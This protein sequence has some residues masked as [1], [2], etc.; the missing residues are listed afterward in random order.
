MDIDI[1]HNDIPQSNSSLIHEISIKYTQNQSDCMQKRN[2]IIKNLGNLNSTYTIDPSSTL[3]SPTL[4]EDAKSTKFSKKMIL[5]HSTTTSISK[6]KHDKQPSSKLTEPKPTAKADLDSISPSTEPPAIVVGEDGTAGACNLL[7]HYVGGEG[8]IHSASKHPLHCSID[9]RRGSLGN[10]QL[11][12]PSLVEQHSEPYNPKSHIQS[13]PIYE[14][15][16]EHATELH[17]NP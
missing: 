14:R 9:L 12:Q 15:R 11:H 10:G 5:S 8:N 4:K 6:P 17:S 16:L 2:S 3:N 13:N 7:Q 1:P